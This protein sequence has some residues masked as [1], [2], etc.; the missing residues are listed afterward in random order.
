MPWMATRAPQGCSGKRECQCNVLSRSQC[1]LN[2][3]TTQV[4]IRWAAAAVA[5]AIFRHLYWQR[6]DDARGR[7]RLAPLRNRCAQ[8][9]CSLLATHLRSMYTK[10]VR[11]SWRDY[12]PHALCSNVRTTSSR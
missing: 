9:S 5:S 12:T 7:L 6:H 4:A 1:K 2:M 10:P 11:E 8:D 3:K